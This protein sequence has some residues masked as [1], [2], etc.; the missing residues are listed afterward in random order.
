MP[1]STFN[2][3]N[4]SKSRRQDVHTSQIRNLSFKDKVP[5]LLVQHA[6]IRGSHF[7][8]RNSVR[9]WPGVRYRTFKTSVV[10][11]TLRR[12]DLP[13]TS[14]AYFCTEPQWEGDCVHQRMY[15]N[16]SCIFLAPPSPW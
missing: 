10:G 6:P 15:G 8:I 12:P 5:C 14:Y 1:P 2:A 11:L 3:F 9:L 16:F 13:L 4:F 7:I